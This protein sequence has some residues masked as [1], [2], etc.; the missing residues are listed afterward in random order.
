M[1]GALVNSSELSN[2]DGNVITISFKSELLRDKMNDEKNLRILK[3]VLQR[4]F[5]QEILVALTVGQGAGGLGKVAG[6]VPGGLVEKAQQELGA[7]VTKI[8]KR[9]KE[10]D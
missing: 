5:K 3:R 2:I 9:K 4:M 10:N 8:E 6:I 7:K 1:V